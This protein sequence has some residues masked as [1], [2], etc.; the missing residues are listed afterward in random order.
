MKTI[1][2][3][4]MKALVKKAHSRIAA[5][6]PEDEPDCVPN[7]VC[8]VLLQLGYEYGLC[9][10]LARDLREVEQLRKVLRGIDVDL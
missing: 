1:H 8:E 10:A 6:L 3:T 5:K 2:R 4:I 7:Y 9:V